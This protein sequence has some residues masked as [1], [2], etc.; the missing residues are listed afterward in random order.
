MLKV[1]IKKNET[2]NMIII[3]CYIYLKGC[4]S[5]DTENGIRK[6]N[7]KSE[8]VG[9][10][11]QLR[12]NFKYPGSSRGHISQKCKIMTKNLGYLLVRQKTSLII[13]AVK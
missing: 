7:W 11:N 4:C 9:S 2:D 6:R 3:E 13:S 10:T 12:S 5:M 1:L 8:I